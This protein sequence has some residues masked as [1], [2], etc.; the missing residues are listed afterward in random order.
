M[1]ASD[2]M[3]KKPLTKIPN[4]SS[5]RRYL[6]A[7]RSSAVVYRGTKQDQ[8]KFMYR[9][10]NA[11]GRKL[12]RELDSDRAGRTFSSAGLRS[13][14]HALD[15]RKARRNGS[16]RTFATH[17]AHSLVQAHQSEPF[18]ELILVAE[19]H[20][21]GLLRHALPRSI[22]K[23]VRHEVHREYIEGSDQKIGTLIHRSIHS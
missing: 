16:A 17:I 4:S 6:V 22:L 18:E 12:E 13:I 20:F 5:R 2:L 15:E 23:M 11:T 1:L 19:P 3:K 7:N 14:H 10:T 21:L 9:L 8:I